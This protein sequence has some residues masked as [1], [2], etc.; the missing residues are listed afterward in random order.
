MI[1]CSPAPW[2]IIK[3]ALLAEIYNDLPCFQGEQDSL[4][5]FGITAAH[6]A[7]TA[8]LAAL[9]KQLSATCGL[10]TSW[11][12]A[13]PGHT[14]A[15]LVA[16]NLRYQ[17][18]DKAAVI[19]AAVEQAIR[20][21]HSYCL[22]GIGGIS[23][24]FLSRAKIVSHEVHKMLGF[25]RFH[26]A[27]DNTLAAKPKLFH[28]TA[29]LILR[30]FAPRYPNTRLVF[31]LENDTALMLTNGKIMHTP[32]NI[33]LPYVENQEF[34]AA[35]ETYYQSQYI[36]TRKNIKLA[37]HAI[38]KKYWDWLAEGKILESEASK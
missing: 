6:D 1:I 11:L 22:C 5:L 7:D 34:A 10:D 15:R 16:A 20:Y 14:L 2:P 32:A 35:W 33:Y 26:P 8:S 19:F 9:I 17:A 37:Q 18:L 13:S 21:G 30:Q 4:G 27:P 25:I 24:I 31:I 23:R 29:D 12:L 36:A 3:A 38:P 28:Q